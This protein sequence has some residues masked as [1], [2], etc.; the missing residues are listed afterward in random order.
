ME[1]DKTKT[2]D[3]TILINKYKTMRKCKECKEYI[4]LETEWD[5][6][7]YVSNAFHHINC[8][9]NKMLNKKIRR[10]SEEAL[11][12]KINELR[13][14]SDEYIYKTMAKSHLYKYLCD[15]YGVVMLPTY[16]YQKMEGIF[17]G[18]WKDMSCPIPP[19]HLL[20][21][22]QRKQDWLNK[23]YHKDNIDGIGRINYDLSVLIGKYRSY[24]DWLGKKEIE[25]KQAQNSSIVNERLTEVVATNNIKKNE[26]D[27]FDEDELGD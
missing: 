6:T 3:R 21:M 7:I 4:T 18:T 20:D 13:L 8:F 11:D 17:N 10:P 27:I 15:A 2:F 26:I 12:I 24:L 16:V 22:F 19:E 23:I 25:N 5:S 9:K 14:S 1:K